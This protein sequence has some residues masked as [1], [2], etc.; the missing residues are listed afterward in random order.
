MWLG[1]TQ[2]NGL[3]ALAARSVD[4]VVHQ[5]DREAPAAGFGDWGVRYFEE[6]ATDPT[7]LVP[8][9]GMPIFTWR[10]PGG[11]VATSYVSAGAADARGSTGATAARRCPRRW[12]AG[13]PPPATADT[14][15]PCT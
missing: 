12:R 15:G 7:G 10:T 14:L 6:T 4:G 5:A 11:L 3:M 9:D 2:G 8:A 1:T 13:R